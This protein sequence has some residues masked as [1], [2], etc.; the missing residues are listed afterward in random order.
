MQIPIMTG[1][2]ICETVITQGTVNA[3]ICTY[4]S[5]TTVIGTIK[6]L[7]NFSDAEHACNLVY[8]LSGFSSC[9]LETV[10]RSTKNLCP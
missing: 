2:Q 7:S 9:H 10:I 8:Q 6:M 4:L 5:T 1:T 3:N